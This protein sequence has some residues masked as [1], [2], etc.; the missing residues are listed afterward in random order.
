MS[1]DLNEL[2]VDMPTLIHI[3]TAR[4]RRRRRIH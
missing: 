2:G 3:G 1:P 4:A